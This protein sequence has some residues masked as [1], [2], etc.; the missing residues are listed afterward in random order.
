MSGRFR[1]FCQILVT[2]FGEQQFYQR[3]IPLR[4]VLSQIPWEVL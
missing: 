2:C 1:L 4:I 3:M